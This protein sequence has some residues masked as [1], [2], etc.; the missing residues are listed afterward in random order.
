LKNS[1]TCPD[2]RIRK[3][4]A[5]K[6]F[7]AA[8][9]MAFSFSTA[10]ALDPNRAMSQY[11]HDRW[12]PE[13]GFPGGAVYAIAQTADGYLWIGTEHGL[14]RFDGLNF[15]LMKHTDAPGAPEGPVSGLTADLEGNLWIRTQY[16]GLLRYREG[17]FQ[18]ILA[19]SAWADNGVTAMGRSRNGQIMFVVPTNGALTYRDGKVVV[20]GSSSGWPHFL[21]ISIA[22]AADGTVWMG[23]RDT[24]LFSLTNGRISAMAQVSPDRKINCLLPLDNRELWIGTDNG[25]ER[26]NGAELTQTGV[27][28]ALE[29]VQT[30]AMMRD[31]EANIWIGTAAGLLRS[32]AAGVSPLAEP[33]QRLGVGIAALF[34]DR[35]RNLWIGGTQG[36]ERLRDSAFLTYSTPGGQ[37]SDNNGPLY[38]DQQNRTWFAPA[39][40]GLSWLKG[41]ETGHVKDASLDKDVVYS[42]TGGDDELW[43]ARQ[44][45]GLTRL[46][47]E[48][49]SFTSQTFTQADGLAQNS[50]YAVHRSR[51]GTVWAGSLS[52]GVSRFKNGRFTNYTTATGLSSNSIVS[53]AEGADGT[54]WFA[55]PNG[56]STLLPQ[57][58]W[59]T[60][61]AREGLPPGNLNCLVQDSGGVLWI[62]TAAGLAFLSGGQ[63]KVPREAPESL[64]EQVYGIA[65]DRSGGLWIATSNHVVRVNREKLLSGTVGNEDVREYGLADGLRG[66]EG[67]KRQ[68]SV[69]TD[70]LGRI[71][72]SL[73]GGISVVDPA[74][75]AGGAVPTL[76]HVLSV[77][78]DGRFM[79]ARDSLRIPPATHRVALSFVGLSLSIPER[80][81]Y[82]YWLDGVDHGWSEP[83]AIREAVYNNLSPGPYRFR[84]QASNSEGLWNSEEAILGFSVDPAF[85]QTP[86]FRAACV[87]ALGLAVFGFYRYRM[88]RLTTQMNLRFE[89]RLAERTRIAQE[90]HDTLLQGFLSAS[91]QL[92]VAAEQISPESP[93]KPRVSRVLELMRQVIDEGRNAVRGLRAP[94]TGPHNLQE[95]LARIPLE[96]EKPSETDFRIIVEG[97]P[98]S[99][100]PVLR[101][102]IYRIGREA[103]VNAFRHSHA[104][105]V[106]VELEYGANQLRLLIRD[107]GCGI[108]PQVLRSGREGHWGLPGMRER[109]EKVGGR[110]NVWSSSTAGTEVEL[111][112]PSHIAFEHQPA[113]GP[114]KRRAG[115]GEK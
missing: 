6:W 63:V 58:R 103:L 8:L 31:Q 32:N 90:L 45:G 70:S 18:N 114:L 71:W 66:V 79:D 88:H 62:G 26:W 56:L 57:N 3:A 43:I 52:N 11:V 16:M 89:E 22:E 65:P 4:Q 55:T 95:A 74:R 72:F 1:N 106:E 102:E 97:R 28:P 82:R 19:V 94:S 81:T 78:A 25:V 104:K 10:S 101:D 115:R 41:I 49:G 83:T 107:N 7:L 17:T 80:V 42:I 84:V 33:G 2:G 92:H 21:V 39:D 54:M 73:N 77:S 13:Q 105:S 23:T 110:L 91:L 51:D 50:I 98:R 76:V 68:A 112:V 29:R 86:W 38:V 35:E 53:I 64:R 46:R 93:A 48:S 87:L 67:V 61:T 27:S 75:L 34:E 99:L 24:G 5:R 12:G 96:M 47:Y 37:H 111:S 36:I 85:W 60:Y 108:D 113:N 59:R 9:G 14:V 109:A 30:L 100:H 44:R 15:H 20:L 69:V 40:G